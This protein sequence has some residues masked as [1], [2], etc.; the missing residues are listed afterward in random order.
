[1]LGKIYQE[2]GVKYLCR[3]EYE[4]I[5]FLRNESTTTSEVE[6]YV[7]EKKYTTAYKTV[8]CVHNKTSVN[9]KELNILI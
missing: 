1:M 7:Q 2:R 3:F 9:K 5:A 8:N 6:H 4:S